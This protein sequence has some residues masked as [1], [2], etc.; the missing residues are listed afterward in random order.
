MYVREGGC[1]TGRIERGR[2][3]EREERDSD[4]GGGGVRVGG[5]VRECV[6]LS[7]YDIYYTLWSVKN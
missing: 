7:E 4:R 3:R 6:L 5:S 2:E 1:N